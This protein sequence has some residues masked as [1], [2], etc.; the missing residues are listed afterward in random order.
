MNISTLR[1]ASPAEQRPAVVPSHGRGQLRPFQPGQS[2]NP[3]GKG[4]EFHEIQRIFR[5]ASTEAARRLI[6]LMSSRDERV[7]LLAAGKVLER[8]WGQPKGDADEPAPDPERE[9]RAADARATVHKL[10]AGMAVPEVWPAPRNSEL[11]P[12]DAAA[13]RRETPIL[14]PQEVRPSASRRR[15]TMPPASWP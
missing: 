5:E 15:D 7:A 8:A 6:E 12:S 10:L 4:G 11:G 3:T 1:A 14:P 2:G 9:T 13:V